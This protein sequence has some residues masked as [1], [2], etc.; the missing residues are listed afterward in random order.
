MPSPGSTVFMLWMVRNHNHDFQAPRYGVDRLSE[1]VDIE[2][3]ELDAFLPAVSP[4]FTSFNFFSFEQCTLQAAI[5]NECS[6]SLIMIFFTKART[7]PHPLI[8]VLVFTP[9]AVV[10]NIP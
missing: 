2:I 5:W 7:I 6:R 10:V 1:R 9:E 4:E 3:S 8:L